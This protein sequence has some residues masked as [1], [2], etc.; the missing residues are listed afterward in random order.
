MTISL[1]PVGRGAD[2][3]ISHDLNFQQEEYEATHKMESLPHFLPFVASVLAKVAAVD[4]FERVASHVT[5]NCMICADLQE[6]Q[7]RAS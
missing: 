2:H 1:T 4:A 7:T 6:P 3:S 5:D